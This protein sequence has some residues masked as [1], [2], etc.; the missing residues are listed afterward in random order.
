M[1]RSGTSGLILVV[2][3]SDDRHVIERHV[4]DSVTVLC[5]QAGKQELVEAAL[6]IDE[7]QVSRVRCLI[8]RDYD[9]STDQTLPL[10]ECIVTS[11]NHD[12]VMDLVLIDRSVI[13][14]VINAHTRGSDASSRS[15][16][17][18]VVSDALTVAA[19]VGALRM[20][21]VQNN[22]ELNMSSF[23]FGRFDSARPNPQAVVE[24]ALSRSRPG[25]KRTPVLRELRAA[26]KTQ[27]DQLHALVGDHDF[28]G[29]VAHLLRSS[30]FTSVG[31]SALA[32]SFFAAVDCPAIMK[33]DW[34]AEVTSWSTEVAG[35]P[36]FMCPCGYVA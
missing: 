20:L 15:F 3:G 7:R 25:P 13:Y 33:T 34:Y 4:D 22:W 28:F 14:R 12:V 10:A 6:L 36:S 21:S 29:A 19:R 9:G 26:L 1:L 18:Q 35:V 32:A 30:G 16:A 31:E 8:D 11:T 2:E 17:E 27:A 23:P 5:G 24:L